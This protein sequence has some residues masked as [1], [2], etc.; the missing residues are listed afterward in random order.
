MSQQE[1]LFEDETTRAQRVA[2]PHPS[3][4][5]KD[6]MEARGWTLKDV[7]ARMG[8]VPLHDYGLHYL[9]LEMYFAVHEPNLRIGQDTAD[10]LGRAFGVNPQFFLNLEAAWLASLPANQ[11]S[12]KEK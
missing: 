6:E 5:I 4:F 2:C 3:E 12:G 1:R 11:L 9:A 7:A 10:A 8:V